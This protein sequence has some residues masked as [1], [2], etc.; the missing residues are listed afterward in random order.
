MSGFDMASSNALE[1]S[2]DLRADIFELSL[3]WRGEIII[4]R[5]MCIES[6][7]QNWMDSITCDVF[8]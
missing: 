4:K 2:L 6:S 3:K 5:S 1:Y 7:E 8:L